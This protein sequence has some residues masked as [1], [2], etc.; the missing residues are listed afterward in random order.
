MID[1]IRKTIQ[2]ASELVRE[3]TAQFSNSAKEKSYEII[4]EWLE[5]IPKL[6]ATGLTVTSFAIGVALS[7]SLEVELTGTHGQFPI[8]RINQI[9]NQNKGNAVIQ[10][11][12]TTVRMAYTFHRKI[13][14]PLK[15]PIIVKIR[16]KLSPE[17]QVFIGE[18][19]IK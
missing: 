11:V 8:E 14:A 4:E 10:S 18:P 5:S 9:I 13:K 7:P 3:Q 17:I 19:V 12:F 16:V 15:E 2:E 6:E 1:K